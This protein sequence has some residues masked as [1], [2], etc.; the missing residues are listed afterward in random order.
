MGRTGLPCIQGMIGMIDL[1]KNAGVNWTV[2]RFAATQ[3]DD[4][5]Y[6]NRA[7]AISN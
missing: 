6:I 3:V 5:T 2:V 7:A 4:D 1:I